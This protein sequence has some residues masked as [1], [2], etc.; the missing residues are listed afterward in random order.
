MG[1]CCNITLLFYFPGVMYDCC[2][3]YTR[4]QL[5]LKIIK[6]FTIQNS[7]EVCDIDA[8]I[9][10]TRKFRVCANPKEQW[11]IN[12]TDAIRYVQAVLL[13]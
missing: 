9:F 5:P 1:L 6:G 7:F 11:V 8:V 10:I 3:T 2:Y 13:L 4:K 12:A